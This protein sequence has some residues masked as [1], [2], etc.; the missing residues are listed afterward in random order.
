MKK[1]VHGQ[2]LLFTFAGLVLLLI[3]LLSAKQTS[4]EQF[5]IRVSGSDNPEI[6]W[7]MGGEQFRLVLGWKSD[8]GQSLT[9]TEAFI[10]DQGYIHV[11]ANSSCHGCVMRLYRQEVDTWR[12][13]DEKKAHANKVYT[14][15][16]LATSPGIVFPK[17]VSGPD[18]PEIAW[19]M[20]GDQYRLVLGW[21][22]SH[23]QTLT[24]REAVT[25]D[26]GH[27]HVKADTSCHGCIMR[28]YRREGDTWTKLD[29]KKAHAHTPYTLSSLSGKGAAPQRF[30][31]KESGHQN[32]AITWTMDQKE[33]RLEL[34]WQDPVEMGW[35]ELAGADLTE[36]M[37]AVSGKTSCEDC[38]VALYEKRAGSWEKTGIVKSM[39][40]TFAF[41]FVT[42]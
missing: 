12:K 6:L 15:T 33:F 38:W 11:K 28:L 42:N 21:K 2:P 23:N 14:L 41:G 3:I 39:G 40:G 35:V 13:L 34:W 37:L 9:I 22:S 19:T 10:D 16:G 30:P 5:P 24:I 31:M 18:N 7:T 20:G 36:G 1:F 4:A 25:D 27:I 8:Y 32:P 26:Q 29:E 17:S